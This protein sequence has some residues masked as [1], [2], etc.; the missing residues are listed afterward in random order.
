MKSFLVVYRRTE[1]QTYLIQLLSNKYNNIMKKNKLG[2]TNLEVSE[3]ALGGGWV[4]G[5][6]IDADYKVM[7]R[8][9]ELALESGINWIDTAES[10]SEGV[11]EK[12]IGLLLAC[13][14]KEEK[15]FVSSKARLD[16]QS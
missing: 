4:G 14:K 7:E 11:S 16:P 1:G 15:L 5:L 12:N 3:I 9:I 10:Y 8:A 13:L 6:F 2:R